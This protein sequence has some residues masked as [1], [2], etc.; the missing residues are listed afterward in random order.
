MG[1]AEVSSAR[2][3]PAS[4]TV[5]QAAMGTYL[6]QSFGNLVSS[7]DSGIFPDGPF[8]LKPWKFLGFFCYVSTQFAGPVTRQYF[9]LR[10]GD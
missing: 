2:W 9:L 8:P 1:W 4:Q 3:L 5:L 7:D 6:G 10:K